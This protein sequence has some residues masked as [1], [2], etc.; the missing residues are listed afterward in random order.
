M[1]KLLFTILC[2]MVCFGMVSTSLAEEIKVTLFTTQAQKPLG[3]VTF[4]D[5]DHGLFIKPQL[6]NLAPGLHGMH[7]HQNPSCAMHGDQAGTHLDPAQTNTHQGPY[8]M[9]HLGDLPALYVDPKG[10]AMLPT[11]APQLTTKDL[12]GHSLI[13]HLGS[14]NYADTPNPAGGGGTRF[15]CGIIQ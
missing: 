1:K 14:D 6:S 13:I 11:L 10:F 12:H 3:Y 8:A 15:A 4:K 7:I 2:I 5:T 9:G